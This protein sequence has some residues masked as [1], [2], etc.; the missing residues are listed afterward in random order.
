M[1]TMISLL[2]SA[3]LVVLV[4][5]VADPAVLETQQNLV[6]SSERTSDADKLFIVD[7][8]LPGQIRKLGSRMTYLTARKAVKTTAVDCEIRGGEYV[9]FDRAN[10]ATSLRIWL[11]KAQSGDSEAQVYT[12]EIY[13]KGLG[14]S[15]DYKTAVEWYRKAAEQGNSR[16]H[17]NL[18]YLYEKGL[19]V[20]KNLSEAM[21]WYRKASGLEQK[22]IPYSA[23]LYTSS[24][25]ELIEQIKLLKTELKNSRSESKAL[26]K[27]LTDTQRQLQES[28]EKLKHF[29]NERNDTQSKLDAAETQGDILEKARLEKILREKDEALALQQQYVASI[30]KQYR[31]KVDDLTEKLEE[32][33]KR[34]KQIRN[35]LK[36]Q[37]TATDDAQLKLMNAEAQLANTQKKLLEAQKNY[38]EIQSKLDGGKYE[39]ASQVN[40]EIQL[41]HQETLQKLHKDLAVSESERQKAQVLIAQLEADKTKYEKEISR[42]QAS[43]NQA[44]DAD[45]PVIEIIDPP[46]VLLRGIPTVT[47]RSS[48]KER[49][50]IGKATSSAGIMSVLVNDAKKTL[51][52]RGIFNASVRIQGEKTP[53]SVVAVDHKGARSSLDF[54]LTL[55]G[56]VKNLQ[57]NQDELEAP[58]YQNP[59]KNIDLGK[60]YAL[61]IGNNHYQKIPSLDTPIND[62][63]AVDQVLRERYGF[64]TKLLIDANRYQILSALNEMRSKLTETDNLLIYYAG[65]GELDQVNMRGHWLPVDAEADN[66]ANWISTVSITDIL[67]AMSSKHILVVADSC[68]SGA[69]T[70]SS[71]ARLDAGMSLEKKSEWL[72]A[73][74]KARSRTVLTSGGLKPVMDGGG[75]DHSIFANAFIKAL[76]SNNGLLE[77]QEL[78]RN[79]SAN[80]VAVA[81][82]YGVEQVPRY[83]PVAHAGHEAGEFFFLPK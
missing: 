40:E 73:M 46:F 79:V 10:Y 59:W 72:K 11:P 36:S 1:K 13:E 32:T 75:G 60:F 80:I 67:N 30:E 27:Q 4:G 8:L 65:H 44:I 43:A 61:I 17:I 49:E 21:A 48:V 83:A 35:Q 82:Q 3:V 41:S 64:T 71:L 70:R 78:Y 29:Q 25:N 50:I 22:D 52:D 45:K 20:E 16:A 51:D 2:K 38:A 68:Y 14:V 69:M 15:P 47:L 57:R 33:E 77:G 76:K 12:G 53:V 18:G 56:A 23:T 42:L 9:A 62:A 34:A 28:L 19:G 54:L 31:T 81:A 58:S 55:E 66:T 37:Q 7:C 5:C 74:L 26:T 39:G 24:D 63:Q 6:A